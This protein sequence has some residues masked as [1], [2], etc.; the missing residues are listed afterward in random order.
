MAKAR[1]RRKYRLRQM[2]LPF[3]VVTPP[4][5]MP[6]VAT[7]RHGPKP[8]VCYF[9]TP[10]LDHFDPPM[11]TG[12]GCSYCANYRGIGTETPDER[13]AH[14]EKRSGVRPTDSG[15]R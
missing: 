2:P 4:V 12:N 13:A 6:P 7:R 5:A 8:L 14:D 10:W 3:D 9:G 11:G 1:R 15:T